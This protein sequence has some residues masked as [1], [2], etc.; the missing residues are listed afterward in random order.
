[1][2]LAYRLS[3]MGN[4]TYD[5]LTKKTASGKTIWS[6][7]IRMNSESVLKKPMRTR[8]PSIFFVNSM[9]DFFH[10]NA[11]DKMRLAALD[12]MRSTIH[13]YQILTKRPDAVNG[14]FERNK[15][16]CPDN[17][18]LGATVE[19][20]RVSERLK[21]VKK[22]PSKIR[23]ISIEPL[24]A[25]MGP[26]SYKGISWVITGGESG[27]NSRPCNADWLRQIRDDLKRDGVPHFFKQW[28]MPKNNP[29]YLEAPNGISGVAWVEK[30]DPIGKGGSLLDGKHFKEMPLGFKV[31]D[32]RKDL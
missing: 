17:V 30:K 5:G 7:K 3:E 4:K 20:N 2:A 19:D 23:F 31:A 29:L 24:T 9:S 6:G 18:W 14:F 16:R 26:Q 10:A 1:M 22:Y 32:F 8:E 28:G 13:Q 21:Y 15:I 12:V 11:T 27:A 25:P